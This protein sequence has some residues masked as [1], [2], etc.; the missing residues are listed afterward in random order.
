MNETIR[1]RLSDRGLAE[2]NEYMRLEEPLMSAYR[3]ATAIIREDSGLLELMEACLEIFNS[4]TESAF[5]A[6]SV[7][8]LAL[9]ASRERQL[10][11][12]LGLRSAMFHALLVP[13]L[14]PETIRIYR[15]KGLPL[16]V[17]ADSMSDLRIWILHYK[18]KR[19]ACGLGNLRWMLHILKARLFRF[20]RLQFMQAA[21]YMPFVVLRNKHSGKAVALPEAG[22]AYREDGLTEGTNG[23]YAGERGWVSRYN[24]N[25]ARFEGHPVTAAATVIRQ[26]RQFPTAEWEVVLRRTDPVVEIHMPEGERMPHDVCLQS[27][28]KAVRF[29][30]EHFP[31]RPWRAFTCLSWLME[32]KLAELIPSSSNIVQ[33][34]SH[35][36][37]MPFKSDDANIFDHVFG[38]SRPEVAEARRDTQLQRAILDYMATGRLLQEAIGVWLAEDFAAGID[39]S[40]ERVYTGRPE[41]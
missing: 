38:T 35:F 23:I 25:E 26:S 7:E 12:A 41:E 30:A 2:A 14:L 18:R 34:Q 32:P 8:L 6:M 21:F 24:E 31:D 20:G 40:P 4:A 13:A 29:Y 1:E 5:R 3:E 22:I 17:L 33:Y 10:S 11:I 16:A 19:N 36:Y 37:K 39:T 15:D 27:M 28:G 9:L